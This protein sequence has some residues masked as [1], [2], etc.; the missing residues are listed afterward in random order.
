MVLSPVTCP[1]S[2]VFVCEGYIYS[3]MS[4]LF[5]ANSFSS[6]GNSGTSMTGDIYL[7][8]LEVV[9]EDESGLFR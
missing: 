8:F 2:L 9:V 7:I 1:F 3:L 6:K 4:D 5:I